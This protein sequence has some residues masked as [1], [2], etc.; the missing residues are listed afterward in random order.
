M[1]QTTKKIIRTKPLPKGRTF[2]TPEARAQ[3]HKNGDIATRL[4]ALARKADL[5]AFAIGGL[6]A[7]E[8]GDE[9]WP[10]QDAAFE[11]KD[12][13]EAIAQGVGL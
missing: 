9:A 7:L 13:L 4:E 1:L 12:A 11:I 5:L 2:K 3:W 6:M 10:M 8:D